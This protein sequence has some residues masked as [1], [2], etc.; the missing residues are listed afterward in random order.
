MNWKIFGL[1]WNLLSVFI[2]IV[3]LYFISDVLN[4]YFSIAESDLLMRFQNYVSVFFNFFVVLMI[5]LN[6]VTAIL[7]TKTERKKSILWLIG[8]SYFQ[9]ML[10]MSFAI[11]IVF[12]TLV[13]YYW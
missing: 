3:I 9:F 8:L 6:I 2:W 11:V 4:F 5:F 12:Y 13:G 1:I 7:A 10:I